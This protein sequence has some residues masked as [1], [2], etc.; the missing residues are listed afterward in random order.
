M[1]TLHTALEPGDVV[2]IPP[3][4]GASIEFVE[5][6]GKRSKV[7]ITCDVPVTITRTTGGPAARSGMQPSHPIARRPV[8]STG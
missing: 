8:P 3:G 7:K 6:T 2:L 1:P 4:A 5:K